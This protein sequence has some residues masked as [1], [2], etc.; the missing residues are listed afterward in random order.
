MTQQQLL[1]D[2]CSEEDGSHVRIELRREDAV[3]DR[4]SCAVAVDPAVL[5][6]DDVSLQ[7]PI[8]VVSGV[9]VGDDSGW[10][11]KTAQN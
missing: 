8:V 7:V 10:D 9:I 5:V 4:V 11:A 6:Q 3:P 1:S 2:I